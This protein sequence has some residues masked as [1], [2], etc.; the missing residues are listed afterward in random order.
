MSFD[1]ILI[2]VPTDKF[3]PLIDWCKAAFG[4]LGLVEISRPLE[5]VVGLGPQPKPWLW[6][7]QM[8]MEGLDTKT[9]NVLFEKQHVAVVGSES[10][11][12]GQSRTDIDSC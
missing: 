11:F 6:F 4:H 5:W 12:P 7:A 8:S 9:V 10:A 1:H 3:E 2:N